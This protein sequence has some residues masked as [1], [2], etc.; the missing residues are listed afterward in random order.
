ME[1][2]IGKHISIKEGLQKINIKKPIDM[3]LAILVVFIADL[4]IIFTTTFIGYTPTMVYLTIFDNFYPVEIWFNI[5]FE[6]SKVHEFYFHN[7][8]LCSAPTMIWFIKC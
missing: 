8:M 2:K 4:T 5:F 7:I 3:I 6:Q 1:N